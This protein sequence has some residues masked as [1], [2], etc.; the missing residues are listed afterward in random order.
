MEVDNYNVHLQQICGELDDKMICKD[1]NLCHLPAVCPWVRFKKAF[2]DGF[3]GGFEQFHDDVLPRQQM[4]IREDTQICQIVF[5][6]L[7]TLIKLNKSLKTD[8]SKMRRKFSRQQ[9]LKFCPLSIFEIEK[10]FKQSGQFYQDKNINYL[11]YQRMKIT[12][13]IWWSL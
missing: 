10:Y 5:E 3:V 8:G 12:T 2:V 13:A 11:V 9:Y 1:T 7:K 6:V 4:I